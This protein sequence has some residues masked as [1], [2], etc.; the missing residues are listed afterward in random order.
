M[1]ATR[2]AATDTRTRRRAASGGCTYYFMSEIR[3]IS[4]RQVDTGAQTER[5]ASS[6]CI[7]ELLVTVDGVGMAEVLRVFR[8]TP[9]K[10]TTRITCRSASQYSGRSDP[11][12]ERLASTVSTLDDKINVRPRFLQ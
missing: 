12:S 11:T 6:A 7:R 2:P 4:F 9:V 10:K 3:Q 8:K 1:R 5:A